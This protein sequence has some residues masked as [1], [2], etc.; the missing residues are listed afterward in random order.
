[1]KQAIEI[2]VVSDVVCPWCWIGKRNL[3]SALASWQDSG[4]QATINWQ[5]FQLNPQLPADVGQ[6][7]GLTNIL[8]IAKVGLK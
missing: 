7:L 5:A 3:E 8:M 6:H 2:I 4:A 1:M